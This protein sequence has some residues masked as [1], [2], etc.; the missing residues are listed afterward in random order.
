M[1]NEKWEE[2]KK[3]EK[4]NIEEFWTILNVEV[5]RRDAFNRSVSVLLPK[6]VFHSLLIHPLRAL[7][8][9]FEYKEREKDQTDL[10]W[11]RKIK[12]GIFISKCLVKWKPF[13]ATESPKKDRA[14]ETNRDE[15]GERD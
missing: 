2:E 15:W 10:E 9:D 11:V 7:P 8:I 12:M 5:F 4:K 14:S 13:F 6:N 3:K 1:V